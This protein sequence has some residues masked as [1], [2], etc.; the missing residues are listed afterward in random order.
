VA[1]SVPAKA[2]HEPREATRATYPNQ[3]RVIA[4]RIMHS[5]KT[6]LLRHA[7][8]VRRDRVLLERHAT[9][10]RVSV[11]RIQSVEVRTFFRSLSRR[12]PTVLNH[13]LSTERATCAI[14]HAGSAAR[15][16]GH[17][18]LYDRAVDGRWT[19]GS[20]S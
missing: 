4:V 17:L 2:S 11:E 14:R 1:L 5:T 8:V 7:G 19:S 3:P 18:Q 13:R 6:V 15:G 10:V 9:S 12:S 16:E 20:C